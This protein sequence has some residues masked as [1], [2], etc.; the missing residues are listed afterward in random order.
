LFGLCLLSLRDSVDCNQTARPGFSS[1]GLLQ[2]SV[3][4][5]VDI[6]ESKSV[7]IE[8]YIQK[9]EALQSKKSMLRIVPSEQEDI[10]SL[11]RRPHSS[12]NTSRSRDSNSSPSIETP[13]ER[14]VE[15]LS[16][17]VRDVPDKVYNE[18]LQEVLQ[19]LNK[20]EKM[21]KGKATNRLSMDSE[22]ALWFK[23][24]LS[25]NCEELEIE[26]NGADPNHIRRNSQ[27]SP[28]TK[29]TLPT[30]RRVTVARDGQLLAPAVVFD[31]KTNGTSVLS[32]RADKDH[33]R[34]QFAAAKRIHDRIAEEGPQ[35]ISLA[36][37]NAFD[38]E[39]GTGDHTNY[40]AL[41]IPPFPGSTFV[42]MKDVEAYLQ[43]HSFVEWEFDIFEFDE[44]CGHHSLWFIP[45]VLLHFYNLI[46]LF[47]ID[48]KKLSAL[49]IHAEETYCFDPSKPNIYHNSL[50]AADV[51]LTSFHY[52]NNENVGKELHGLHGFSFI[53]A[54][55]FHDYRHPG[56]NNQ[57]LM[58]T[59]HE[60][61]VIYND[62]SVLENFHISQAYHLFNQDAFKIFGALNNQ[63]LRA[64]RSYFIKCILAT[65]LAHGFEYLSKFKNIAETTKDF[66][67]FSSKILL[68]QM[69]LKC[70]DVAHPSKPWALHQKWSSLIA[71]EFY[72]QGDIEKEQK[73]QVSPLCDRQTSNLPKLQCDFIDLVV[74]PYIEPF[75]KFC[76]EKKWV[77][78]VQQNYL[79]WKIRQRVSVRNL[80]P[81]NALS[82]KIKA[83][84][85]V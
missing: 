9:P 31:D 50:H 51:A 7:L 84:K 15:I 12:P 10:P 33:M 2:T 73:L 59:Q 85:S 21:L 29:E 3:G 38:P 30:I 71:E 55:V 44:I 56:L 40:N 75:S 19:I 68:M 20:P 72:A 4:P 52:C 53:L 74:R 64:F 5:D 18:Q 23:N 82:R 67:D 80:E 70:A 49:L 22:T 83:R 54:A 13:W 36:T 46:G 41:I 62:S 14:A 76:H 65:D 43:N 35:E 63:E 24:A 66:S 61:A 79:E 34:R 45:M 69:A 8:K 26:F 47:A 57:Y 60:I 37:L 78:T 81:T 58:Q 48:P 11:S 16:A 27:T 6:D 1:L 39:R 42:N 28:K 25:E 32:F 77:A 17:L